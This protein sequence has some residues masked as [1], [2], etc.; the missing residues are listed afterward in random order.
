MSNFA[1]FVLADSVPTMTPA[2][3]ATLELAC[4]GLATLAI[5]TVLSGWRPTRSASVQAA[6]LRDSV[7]TNSAKCADQKRRAA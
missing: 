4:V 6:R 1:I 5:Y 2:E 7:G 3:P